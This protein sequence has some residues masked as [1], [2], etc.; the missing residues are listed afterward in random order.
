MK[1]LMVDDVAYSRII[2]QKVLER[3]GFEVLQASSGAE[4]LRTLKAEW[5]IALVVSDLMMPDINGVELAKSAQSLIRSRQG[6]SSR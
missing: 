5:D 1:V 6:T 4:A 3:H 2:V